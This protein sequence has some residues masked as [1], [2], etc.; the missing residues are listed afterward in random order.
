MHCART[1]LTLDEHLSRAASGQGHSP[2]LI[3]ACAAGRLC[4]I[5]EWSLRLPD[6]D[7]SY[8]MYREWANM[9]DQERS[10]ALTGFAKRQVMCCCCF[11]AF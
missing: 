4:V 7:P 11:I 9:N 10:Q 3:D 2:G 1:S 5:G 8:R 6:W